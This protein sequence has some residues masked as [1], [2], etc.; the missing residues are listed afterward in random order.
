MH[1]ICKTKICRRIQTDSHTYIHS[2][3][4]GWMDGWMNVRMNICVLSV[5]FRDR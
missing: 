4:V 2:S 1:D 3:I 5:E